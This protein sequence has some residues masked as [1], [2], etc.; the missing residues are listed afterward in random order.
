MPS[1]RFH[2]PV[3]AL[4]SAPS[5]CLSRSAA[6]LIALA[7]CA[8]PAVRAQQA[9]PSSLQARQVQELYAAGIASVRQGHIDE[10]ISTFAKAL[11]IAPRDKVV[12]DAVGAAYSLRGDLEHARDYFRRS[13]Q[14]DPE[15]VPALRNLGITLFELGQYQQAGD[16][17]RKLQAQTGSS[18]T[19]ALLFLGMI[20]EKQSD[21]NAALPLL[22][23]AGAILYQFPEAILALAE[24]ERRTGHAQRAEQAL[25][26]F[27]RSANTT[28]AQRQQAAD[29]EAKL[30]NT[31]H[32]QPSPGQH[33]RGDQPSFEALRAHAAQLEKDGQLA[34]AQKLFESAAAKHASA[35]ILVDFA[36]IAKERGDLA[37]AMKSLQHAAELEPDREDSY[38]EFSTICSDHGND[39]LALETAEIGL[40]HVPNSYRLTV[41]KGAVQEKLGQLKEAEATLRHGMEMQKNNGIARL[42]L[43]VVLAH[44]GRTDEAEQTLSE[45][46]RLFPD[47]YY[48]YYFRAKLLAQF[49][50]DRSDSEAL[51]QKAKRSLEQSIRLKPDYPDAHYQLA[52]LY[53]Q[54]SPKLAEQQLGE[55]LKLDPHHLPAQ[56]SLARLYLRTG[57][58]AE[59]KALLAKFKA[60]Q[61]SE[62]LQQQR[63]LRIDVA[64]K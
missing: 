3:R 52:E 46:I 16:Q 50:S 10:G 38:L 45:A 55:C 42:S 31:G 17:F 6:L 57:R 26:A 47:N 9:P 51:K 32:V 44:S 36:R 21:C 40:S 30:G 7:C 49:A 63:Q 25:T 43:A 18:H 2:R 34:E 28:P 15:F 22:R 13:L 27:E 61:R 64:Q 5:R 60:Q 14:S 37:T 8:T 62:E 11:E 12:L 29:L 58:K 56:Y 19:V 23:N 35:G 39:P 20:A 1:T 53:S 41:Q 48:M 59:G 4:F 24:C 33:S 54:D